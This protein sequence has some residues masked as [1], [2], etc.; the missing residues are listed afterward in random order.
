M[1]TVHCGEINKIS[2]IANGGALLH[3]V[4]LM[5][6]VSG[7]RPKMKLTVPEVSM[8]GPPHDTTLNSGSLFL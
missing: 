5:G 6:S 8:E 1:R 2:D 3:Q 7:R 4:W